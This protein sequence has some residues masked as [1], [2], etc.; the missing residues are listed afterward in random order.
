M[1]WF[2]LNHLAC[3]AVDMA[4]KP[5]LLVGNAT[6]V[7]LDEVNTRHAQEVVVR[8]NK[9]AELLQNAISLTANLGASDFV[10]SSFLQFLLDGPKDIDSECGYPVWLTPDHYRV[11]YDREGI[12]ARVV[13]CEPEESWAMDPEVYEDDDP[14]V[15]TPFEEAWDSICQEFNLYHFLQ[16]LDVISGIGQFGIMVVGIDDGEDLRM[17]VEGINDDGT[18]TAGKEHNLLYIR[19]F[20]ESVVFVKVRE[21]DIT[22]PRY[23]LP[24]IYTVQFRDYPNWGVQAGE[25]VA[26]DI[27]WTRVIH[28]ADKR[29]MSEVYGI[30][31]MQ[32]V[33]NRLYD[34]RKVYS[35]SG[36]AFW[37]GAFPSLSF[38]INPEL[39][40]QGLE[41]DT[42][43]IKK[44]F[45][46][47]SNGM[48]RYLAVQGVTTKTIP[49]MV[50][51][52][53]GTVEAHLKAIAI[54]KGIPYR[55]LFGSEEAKLAGTQDSRS[56]NKKLAKR[57]TKYLNPMIIRPF[58][59]RL[60]AMGV[61]PEPEEYQIEWPDLNAP[62]DQDKSNIALADTQAMA[63]YVGGN[64]SMLMPPR[65]YFTKIMGYSPDEADSILEAANEFSSDEDE[66]LSQA[67]Q[68]GAQQDM[69]EHQ[70]GLDQQTDVNSE[71]ATNL[72]RNKGK[73]R[74]RQTHKKTKRVSEEGEGSDSEGGLGGANPDNGDALNFKYLNRQG[75]PNQVDP[76]MVVLPS[77]NTWSDAAR[78]AAMDA[79]LAK[80][81]GPILAKGKQNGYT[82]RL[83]DNNPEIDD[84]K[85]IDEENKDR[86]GQ[87]KGQG[88]YTVEGKKGVV[89]AHQW[90]DWAEEHYP[91]NYKSLPKPAR[92]ALEIEE[93]KKYGYKEK[94]ESH[95]DSKTFTSREHL[96]APIK[97]SEKKRKQPLV[98]NAWSDAARLASIEA[99]RLSTEANQA[100]QKTKL[101]PSVENHLKAA[102]AHEAAA[103]KYW[104]KTKTFQVHKDAAA[105]HR[106][107]THPDAKKSDP[108]PEP[109]KPKK[110]WASADEVSLPVHSS[111]TGDG[112]FEKPH[113]VTVGEVKG[114]AK[115]VG[116]DTKALTHKEEVGVMAFTHKFDSRIRNIDM[117]KEPGSKKREG[118]TEAEEANSRWGHEAAVGFHKSMA[119]EYE[120]KPEVAEAHKRAAEAHSRAENSTIAENEKGIDLITRSARA[121]QYVKAR[122][123]AQDASK[124]APDPQ[125]DE[126]DEKA[127]QHHTNLY[128]ALP[129]LP[130]MKGNV[131]RGLKRQ[132]PEQMKMWQNASTVEEPAVSSYSRNLHTGIGFA[133]IA[134]YSGVNEAPSKVLLVHNGTVADI[135]HI[136][137]YKHEEEVL[138]KKGDSKVVKRKY[139]AQ[140]GDKGHKFLVIEGDQ[141]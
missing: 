69:A 94:F 98:L 93:Q 88:T 15:E 128:S 56:W 40:D 102:E 27:H 125:V 96:E 14:E 12:A 140:T 133:G 83:H 85:H 45:E 99:R 82:L 60:I 78:E 135:H 21:I 29:K 8:R 121:D 22:S 57:Q 58:I 105:A 111:N 2:V 129:K 25:I 100:S 64:V 26:R 95:K 3:Y 73:K 75:M 109:E 103:G 42:E 89:V 70:A 33:W 54:S 61:L 34:L 59:D 51:D 106:N 108:K 20:D 30:P 49:P 117:G 39:A 5:E 120:D 134:N 80:I 119:I 71:P 36:E 110:E 90:A 17:P 9:R 67:G 46:K 43:S 77:L 116:G 62:T 113:R 48:Q 68:Q 65:E 86:P 122:K 138:L 139:W 52:P 76:Q 81:H 37:K 104:H 23:G 6:G 126:E 16:R 7:S 72:V 66:P 124:V 118:H 74:T 63:A 97:N 1:G 24:K 41:L 47:Y 130:M 38:E 123:E 101:F 79:R 44:E 55:I 114:K 84:P 91:K 18:W 11:M 107:F 31:R 10:R 115:A 131:V 92:A 4:N 28:A 35:S 141:Q 87:P 32:Q 50:V 53:S 136:S 137:H 127:R 19:V 13:E 112:S 132:T